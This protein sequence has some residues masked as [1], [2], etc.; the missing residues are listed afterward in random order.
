MVILLCLCM[1]GFVVI[2]IKR[3]IRQK[4]YNAQRDKY[5]IDRIARVEQ[6]VKTEFATILQVLKNIQP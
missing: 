1:I 5:L 4:R 3:D 6:L 2:Q